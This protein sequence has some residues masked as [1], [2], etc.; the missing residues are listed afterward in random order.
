MWFFSLK[1]FIA[2]SDKRF[3]HQQRKYSRVL[4]KLAI[5]KF[6]LRWLLLKNINSLKNVFRLW[7]AK[8]SHVKVW[9]YTLYRLTNTL[10]K[11]K[12]HDHQS[13]LVFCTWDLSQQE[14]VQRN[15][16]CEQKCSW[17]KHYLWTNV[18]RVRWNIF[19]KWKV[20]ML[21]IQLLDEEQN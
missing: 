17:Y 3:L 2:C 19:T 15:W 4:G 14:F 21:V 18:S 9:L 12:I 1:Y 16:V 20:Q 7:H 5:L 8:C 11:S 13:R 10:F 6:S